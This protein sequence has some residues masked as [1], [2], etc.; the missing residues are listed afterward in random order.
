MLMLALD[1]KGYR[2][3]AFEAESGSAA[4]ADVDVVANTWIGAFTL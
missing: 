3:I 2:H 1:G 4:E